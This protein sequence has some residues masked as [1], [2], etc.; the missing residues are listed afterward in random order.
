MDW[1][2]LFM[3]MPTVVHGKG[4]R[5][6][7]AS[8]MQMLA[9]VEILVTGRAGRA[10][11]QLRGTGIVLEDVLTP[12]ETRK[13]QASY[14]RL[15]EAQDKGLTAQSRRGRFLWRGSA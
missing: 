3:N 7:I 12:A 10:R 4:N 9:Q 15:F 6:M 1:G 5:V 2:P 13:K 11:R 14:P 8:T